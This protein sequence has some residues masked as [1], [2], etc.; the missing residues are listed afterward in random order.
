MYNIFT[1]KVCGRPLQWY[2]CPNCNGTGKVH[3][4][5]CVECHG[6]GR[7]FLCPEQIKSA[8]LRHTIRKITV[9]KPLRPL[10]L[11]P[12]DPWSTF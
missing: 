9:P 3:G 4:L 6:K 2:T 12:F 1:C 7:G 8:N 10:R 11:H 5:P